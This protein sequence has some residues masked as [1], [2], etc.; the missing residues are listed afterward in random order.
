M[1]V[2]PK[3]PTKKRSSVALRKRGGNAPWQPTDDERLLVQ[4]CMA[5]GDFTQEQIAAA[6]RVDCDTLVKH[7]K[8]ELAHGRG[9]LNAKV[10]STLAKKAIE[11][12][13][14]ALIWYEKTRRGFR[15]TTRHEMTGKDGGP[16]DSRSLVGVVEVTP[17]MTAAQAAEA[18]QKLLG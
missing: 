18:Y 14:G 16:I 7:C 15:D 11:G 8:A 4:A 2:K 9:D 3:K 1:A 5:T 10:G 13:L 12:D 6:L 17:D